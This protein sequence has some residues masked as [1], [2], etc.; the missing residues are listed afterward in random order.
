M[1]RPGLSIRCIQSRV[2]LA[3][4]CI[5]AVFFQSVLP[6]ASGPV[7]VLVLLIKN[8]DRGVILKKEDRMENHCHDNHATGE[9]VAFPEV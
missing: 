6:C 8:F 5:L 2:V 9:M 4:S 3:S 7:E 1:P